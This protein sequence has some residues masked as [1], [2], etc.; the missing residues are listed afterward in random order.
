MRIHFAGKHPLKFHRGDFPSQR[1]ERVPDGVYRL[2][3]V[4]GLGDVEKLTAKRQL[5]LQRFKVIDKLLERDLLASQFLY[6]FVVVPDFRFFEFG[7]E[8]VT[9]V[10]FLSVVK[11]T[12]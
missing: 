6:R 8:L 1:I 12:P 7:A 5:P 3:V 2:F 9:P 10:A 11:D 4:F